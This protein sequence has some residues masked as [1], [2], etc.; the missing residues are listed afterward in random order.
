MKLSGNSR[1]TSLNNKKN[2]IFFIYLIFVTAV[3]FAELILL[4]YVHVG[5]AS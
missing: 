4:T 1:Y 3:A 5:L 2:I